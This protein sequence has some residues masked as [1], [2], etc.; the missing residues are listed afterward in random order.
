[1]SAVSKRVMPALS[2]A[3]T[4][5]AVSLRP[6]R[7]PKLL[8]PKP[9]ALTFNDPIVRVSIGQPSLSAGPCGRTGSAVL[10]RRF[11]VGEPWISR[12]QQWQMAQS[13]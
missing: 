3:P 2:A 11:G 13:T 1:M 7:M 4:T 12:R 6:M 5:A 9:T 8:Q 10:Y